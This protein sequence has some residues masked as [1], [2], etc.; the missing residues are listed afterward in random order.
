M[1]S[2]WVY[3][4]EGV[5]TCVLRPTNVVGPTLKNTMSRLLRLPRVPS[6]AGYNPMTQFIHEDDLSRAIAAALS[7]GARGVY[8]VA[9]GSAVPWRTALELAGARTFPL[10]SSLV[11]GYLRAFSAF[12]EYLV[13]FFKFPCVI[14]DAVFREA[15][16]FA[17]SVS[18][19]D[20]LASTAAAARPERG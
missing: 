17:P 5:R 13:N 6:L 8:N 9:G 11:K 12:P 4:H 2:T 16:G 15:T 18:V 3:K 14:G 7:S 10:P 19:Q 20:T 1:A